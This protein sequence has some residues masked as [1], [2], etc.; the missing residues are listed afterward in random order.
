MRDSAEPRDHARR[1]QKAGAT[2]RAFDPE[3]MEEAKKLLPSVD[4][5]ADAYEAMDGA[6]ALVI[7]TEWNEF[8]ALDLAR[9]KTL[10]RRRRR[11]IDLRNIYKP[12]DMAEAGFYYF[13]IGRAS[14]GPAD[15]S[16]R[17]EADDREPDQRPEE[18]R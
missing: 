10:L 16:R 3:G 2:I 4:F 12:A 14:A 8:R 7:I 9:V 17:L 18:V 15:A 5:C 1:L 11:S 6:D 13:S